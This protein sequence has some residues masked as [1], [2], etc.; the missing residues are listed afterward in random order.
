VDT[1]ARS[2]QQNRRFRIVLARWGFFGN[3]R[4]GGPDPIDVAVWVKGTQRRD[5]LAIAQSME[6]LGAAFGVDAQE[7]YIA[8]GG[9]VTVDRW[10]ETFA[11]FREVLLTPT[12]PAAEV[13]KEREALLNAIR[14]RHENIFNV[15]EERFRLEMYGTHPYG[16]PDEGTEKAV[17]AMDREALVQWHRRRL[18]L[19]GAVLVTVGNLPMKDLQKD[20]EGLVKAWSSVAS[21]ETAAP[22]APVSYP[23]A[24]RAV[25]ETR[26]FEQGYIMVGYPAP[27]ATHPDY[28]A[29]KLINALLGG[30]MSSPLFYAV[31]EQAGLAYEVSSFY[32]S[33]NAGSALV[34]Y[35]GT[36]PQ[37]VDLAESKIHEVIKNFLAQPPLESDV[38]D[39]KNLI[40]GHY[41]M[42]HQTNARLAWYLGWWELLGKGYGFDTVYPKEIAEVTP[43][44]IH[45]VAKKAFAAPS[46]TVRVRSALR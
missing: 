36:D 28:P 18:S 5:A 26:K 39:A 10:A 42:D 32:S 4:P 9:Q 19:K 33:R 17:S 21:S 44:S 7:D 46:V 23:T 29:F 30:G 8:L 2:A 16:R 31:R 1:P 27:S 35:A 6:L 24:I 22:L 41:L 20:V 25:E 43:A 14:T 12:F 15:A 34:I 45:A 11:L 38:T 40:R 13:E 3:P 37:K